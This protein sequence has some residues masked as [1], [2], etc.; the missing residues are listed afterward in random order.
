MSWIAGYKSKKEDVL[1]DYDDII[2]KLTQM[3]LEKG[4]PQEWNIEITTHK[5]KMK[6]L[7]ENFSSINLKNQQ[8]DPRN[9]ILSTLTHYSIVYTDWNTKSSFIFYEESQNESSNSSEF[10]YF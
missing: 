4:N 8:Q 7:L 6:N 2:K 5:I 9:V 3:N 10:N 1:K